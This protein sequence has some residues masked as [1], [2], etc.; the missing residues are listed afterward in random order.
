MYIY[1]YIYIYMFRTNKHLATPISNIYIR[2]QFVWTFSSIHR[3]VSGL[4]K[5]I[6]GSVVYG[7]RPRV[8][9]HRNSLK[10]IEF[11]WSR[12]YGLWPNRRPEVK[13]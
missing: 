3:S 13:K 8:T 10:T 12:V 4:F 9:D 5:E 7:L 1:A 2:R 6:L 11:L